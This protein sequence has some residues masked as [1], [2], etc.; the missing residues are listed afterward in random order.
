MHKLKTTWKMKL[1]ILALLCGQYVAG[2][3]DTE[4]WKHTSI[5]EMIV[6]SFKDSDGD[7]IGDFKGN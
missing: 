1:F 7:G 5:Y 4:W 2:N 6:H 3:L